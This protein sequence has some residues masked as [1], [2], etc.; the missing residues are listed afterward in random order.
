MK[1]P[2]LTVWPPTRNCLPRSSISSC[3]GADDR[4]LAHLASDDRGVRGHAAG[5]G[6]NALRHEHAVDVVGH[7][8]PPN[9]DDLLAL[10]RPLDGVVGRKHHLAAGRAG[11]GRQPFGRHR[12]LLPLGL[13]EA[14]REQLV[15]RLR[16][17]QQHRFLRRDELLG[18]QIGRDHDRRVA[19]ALAAARLQHEEALVLN[20]E[21]EVLDVLVVLLE[22]RGDVAQL[23][24]GLRHHL[25]ELADRL[26]RADAGDDVLA[27]RVDQEFA[28]E[29]LRRRSPGCA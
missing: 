13:V 26:R 9:Q 25:F 4:R 17:D 14:G 19:G 21:L 29:L 2:S 7:R 27:L 10:L 12:N 5:G 18:H 3:A 24:V 8:L 28:V 15:E 1:S 20:R 16:I 11:R 22:P 6:Q 23:L